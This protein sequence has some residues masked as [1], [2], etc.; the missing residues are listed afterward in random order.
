M[1]SSLLGP[2]HTV[3]LAFSARYSITLATLSNCKASTSSSVVPSTVSCGVTY[4]SGSQI[5][6]INITGAFSTSTSYTFLRV[7]F[8]I[9]NPYGSGQEPINVSIADGTGT[10]VGYGTIYT[11]KYEASIM[12]NCSVVSSSQ[13]TSAN[14]THTY[15]FNPA[16]ML[17]AQS[18][19]LIS[20]PPW[21][22]SYGNDATSP[23]TCTGIQVIK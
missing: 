10:M 15:S 4:F 19:L 6:Q 5:Y 13:L 23:I 17:I 22:G 7:G 11:P 21:S 3:G 9:N 8:T 20:M 12:T 18:Y 2:S 1:P 14:A 16:Q